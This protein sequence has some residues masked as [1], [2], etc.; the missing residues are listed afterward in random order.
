[1]SMAGKQ[2]SLHKAG[3]VF[4]YVPI[5]N[6]DDE[7][8]GMQQWLLTSSS[9]AAGKHA[10][11]PYMANTPWTSQGGAVRCCLLL[12]GRPVSACSWLSGRACMTAAVESEA[13][14]AGRLHSDKQHAT[15]A[16]M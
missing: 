15:D 7:Y 5:P 2:C 3:V 10:P 13:C 4:C 14:S 8:C 12:Q 11:Q 16:E 1:M 6:T 9:H